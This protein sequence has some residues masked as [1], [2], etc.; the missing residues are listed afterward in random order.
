MRFLTVPIQFP[1][2]YAQWTASWLSC[3]T[4][5]RS[6]SGFCGGTPNENYINYVPDSARR[7][8][9]QTTNL[10][11]AVCPL[12]IAGAVR[13]ELTST[14]LETAVLPLNYAPKK[15]AFYLYHNP[16]TLSRSF[17][18]ESPVSKQDG[19]AACRPGHPCLRDAPRRSKEA[20]RPDCEYGRKGGRAAW[21]GAL[22][23]LSCCAHSPALPAGADGLSW[24]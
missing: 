15:P 5:D 1:T 21:P 3:C 19:Q 22:P 8:K 7:I 20:G 11:L 9:K 12:P 4:L 13:V 2:P 24:R 6:L 17:Y 14:V 16:P 10:L 18:H 23:G